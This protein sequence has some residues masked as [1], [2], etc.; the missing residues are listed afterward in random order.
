[1][2]L[3]CLLTMLGRLADAPHGTSLQPSNPV[4]A[5]NCAACTEFSVSSAVNMKLEASRFGNHAVHQI[6]IPEAE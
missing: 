4:L 1:M 3:T 6:Q 5:S 2:D